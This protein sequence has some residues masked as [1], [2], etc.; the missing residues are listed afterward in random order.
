[1]PAP[2]TRRRTIVPFWDRLGAITRYPLQGAVLLS[3]G[4]LAVLRLVVYLPFGFIL[5]V[6]VTIALY[7]YAFQVLRATANGF[8]DPP[9]GMAG[10]EDYLARDQLILQAIFIIV[11]V[12]SFV[13]LG[14]VGGLGLSLLLAAMLPGATITLAID[15]SLGS[16]LNPSRWMDV[17]RALGWPYLALVL[18]LYLVQMSGMF[19]TAL[20]PDV[21]PEFLQVIIFYFF[22]HYALIV[23]FHLTGYLMLQ[24][25]EPLG[26]EPTG[27]DTL[28]KATDEPYQELLDDVETLVRDGDTDGALERLKRQVTTEGG[29]PA[30]HERYRKLL[31]AVGTPADLVAHTRLWLPQLLAAGQ[32]K[33]ALD[34]TREA[35]DA[36]PGFALDDPSAVTRMSKQAAQMGFWELALRLTHGFHQRFPQHPDVVP[37]YLLA[38]RLMSEKQNRDAQAITLLDAL[39]ARFGDHP[40]ISGV[41]QLRQALA[42]NA[43]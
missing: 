21:I 17:A 40:D 42:P 20:V 6:L 32:T 13:L 14:P 3:I 23:C 2:S 4:V 16:A 22:Q 11:A 19:A 25:H 37:N 31:K 27:L 1:M 38:A 12:V 41:R 26:F 33:A 7:K 15:Q 24:F 5:N 39:L 43:R 36:D 35:A 8:T 29:T 30:V 18:L 28:K 34:A 9:E 10:V